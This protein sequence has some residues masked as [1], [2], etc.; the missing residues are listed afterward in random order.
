MMQIY[1]LSGLNSAFFDR[2]SFLDALLRRLLPL[3]YK[4]LSSFVS[5]G[6][7]IYGAEDRILYPS[8]FEQHYVNSSHF[9]YHLR[10]LS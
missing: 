7:M 1:E 3:D 4:S 2:E 5:V 9:G 10:Q 6:S 8:I